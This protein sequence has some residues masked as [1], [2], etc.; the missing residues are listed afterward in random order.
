MKRTL[1]FTIAGLAITLMA[2]TAPAR[3]QGLGAKATIAFPFEVNGKV[4]PAGT[5]SF[6]TQ[7]PE[8][9]L[10]RSTTDVRVEVPAMIITRLAARGTVTEPDLVFDKVGTRYYLSEVWLQG[11]DGYLVFAA[12]GGHSHSSVKAAKK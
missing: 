4:L 11:E 5:Y 9:L 10:V 1:W 2:G 8:L 12:K 3:A 6:E 7:S